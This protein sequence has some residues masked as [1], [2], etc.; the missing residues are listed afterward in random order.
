MGMKQVMVRYRVKSDRVAE[1]DELVRSV[2]EELEREAPE[3]FQYA[4]FRLD[5]G[6]TFVHLALGGTTDGPLP[7]LGAFKR[8]QEGIADRFEEGPW[9]AS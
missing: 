9:S 7:R 5:D 8:F 1:N 3:G 6:Q 2:Y 4:T